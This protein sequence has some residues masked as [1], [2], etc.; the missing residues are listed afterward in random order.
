MPWIWINNDIT[1]SCYQQNYPTI[2]VPDEI[3]TEIGSRYCVADISGYYKFDK[4]IKHLSF[5]TSAD[6]CYILHINN[7][8]KIINKDKVKGTKK[9]LATLLEALK[10]KGSELDKYKIFVLHADVEEEAKAFLENVRAVAPNA[11]I[12]LQPIG[13]VI[14]SHCGP[15]TIGLIMTK[16]INKKSL[17]SFM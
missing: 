12:V 10:T 4:N 6:S 14:G 5:R 1:P 2:M 17:K 8:G 7:E 16:K 11:D 13:P 15:G 3:K 9:A